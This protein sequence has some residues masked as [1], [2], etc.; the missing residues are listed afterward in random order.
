MLRAHPL[1]RFPAGKEVNF[2]GSPLQRGFD[3]YSESMADDD[4]ALAMGEISVGYVGLP[5]GRI[6]DLRTHYPDVRL[7]LHVRHPVER[8][9]SLAKMRIREAGRDLDSLSTAE[10]TDYLFRDRNIENGDYA[11]ALDR[12]LSVFP[13]EQMLVSRFEDITGDPRSAFERLCAHIGVGAAPE[14]IDESLEPRRRKPPERPL[15]DG[16]RDML[17]KLYDES[18]RRFRDVYGIDYT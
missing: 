3:W 10:L 7:F 13:A 6:R 18:L 8:A 5:L 15:P 16:L 11:A 12:W 4:P 1:V 2:W 9:W 17:A 14:V